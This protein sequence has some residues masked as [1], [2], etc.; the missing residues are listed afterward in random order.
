MVRVKFFA[1]DLNDNTSTC[2]N[3]LFFEEIDLAVQMLINRQYSRLAYSLPKFRI[4]CLI[5]NLEDK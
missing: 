2:T 4:F 5:E 3:E 1:K